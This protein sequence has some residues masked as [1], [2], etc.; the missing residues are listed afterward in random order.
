MA[1]LDGDIKME[2]LTED[3]QNAINKQQ[4]REKS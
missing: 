2:I 4:K 3:M 1:H